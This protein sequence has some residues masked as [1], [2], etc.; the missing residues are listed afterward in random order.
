MASYPVEDL[1]QTL[2]IQGEQDTRLTAAR[3]LNLI[4]RLFG[5]VTCSLQLV[6]IGGPLGPWGLLGPLGPLGALSMPWLGALGP[7]GAVTISTRT[8]QANNDPQ[9]I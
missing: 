4:A 1:D 7:L 5:F 2:P 3:R 6:V 8:T 9:N